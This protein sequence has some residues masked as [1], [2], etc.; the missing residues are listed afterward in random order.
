MM[1]HDLKVLGDFTD[2]SL[3][4]QFTDKQLS[5]LL[6]TPDLTESDGTGTESMRLFDTTC[7][8]LIKT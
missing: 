4:R 8:G 2:E 1:S 6:I 3:E 5:R 7:S